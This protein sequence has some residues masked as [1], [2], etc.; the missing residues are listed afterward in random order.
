MQSGD[1]G[2]VLNFMVSQSKG[3]VLENLKKD[4]GIGLYLY[5]T[6]LESFHN[7]PQDMDDLVDGLSYCILSNA[8]MKKASKAAKAADNTKRRIG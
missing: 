3:N 4:L 2:A 1:I 6:Y 8:E 7:L 5:Y